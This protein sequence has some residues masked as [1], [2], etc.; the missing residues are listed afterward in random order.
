MLIDLDNIVQFSI[1]MDEFK[2]NW[3]FTDENNIPASEE[4]QDQIRILTTEAAEFLWNFEMSSV[5]VCSEENYK[6]I[7]VFD[8]QYS[9]Q[10]KIKI[11]LYDL[12]I[13]FKQKVFMPMQPHT[14]F[15]LTWKMV[16]KYAHTLFSASDQAVWDKT[17]NWKLEYH[18]DGEFAFGK[19]VI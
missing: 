16:I 1:P 4:H 8:S 19:N 2:G 11:Y 13:P 7:T 6:D 10:K 5:L 18:H 3:L 15:V 17:L 9:N 14:G 12:G